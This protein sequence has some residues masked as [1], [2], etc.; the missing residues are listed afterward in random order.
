MDTVE[1]EPCSADATLEVHG[2]TDETQLEFLSLYFE[3]KRRSGGGT[4]KSIEYRRDY[5]LLTFENPAVAENVLANGRHKFN[6]IELIVRRARPQDPGKLLLCGLNPKTAYQTLEL[7]LELITGL[8]SNTMTVH[9]TPDRS[10]A[11]IHFKEALSKEVLRKLKEKFE[12]RRLDGASVRAEQ[13]RVTDRVLVENFD[14]DCLLNLYFESPRSHGGSVTKVTRLPG[15]R[16]VVTFHEWEAVD[17]VLKHEQWLKGQLLIIRPH[18]DFL[19]PPDSEPE[20]KARADAKP[21]VSAQPREELSSTVNVPDELKMELLRTS[22]LLRELQEAERS[23]VS[24]QVSEGSVRVTSRDSLLIER[25]K[26]RIL[27][28]LSSVAQATLTVTADEARFLSRSEVRD[29]LQASLL[30]QGAPARYSLSGGL[31]T[32][33][34]FS[35]ATAQAIAQLI[36][37]ELSHINV[38]VSDRQ[39]HALSSPDWQKLVSS[40]RCCQVQVSHSGDRVHLLTLGEFRAEAEKRLE[41]YFGETGLQESVIVMESGKLRFL[42]DNY[43]EVLAGIGQVSIVPL[44]GNDITGLRI[45]G[46][47]SACQP[48]DELLRSIISSICSSTVMLQ[49]PGIARFLL[50]ERGRNI[51]KQLETKYRCTFGLER[52]RWLPLEPEHSLDSSE[53]WI[54]PNFQRSGSGGRERSIQS[55]QQPPVSV[56]DPNGN[57]L[58]LG[59]ITNLIASIDGDEP[60][61]TSVETGNEAGEIPAARG[62]AATSEA[63]SPE[64][65]L[66]TEPLAQ[67]MSMA[68]EEEELEII[69]MDTVTQQEGGNEGDGDGERLEDSG[70]MLVASDKDL[71]FA[72]KLSLETFQT[73]RNLDEDAQ[74]LLALQC[75]MDNRSRE[76][77]E[78][79]KALELSMVESHRS[80]ELEMSNNMES[81]GA[82]AME[83]VLQMSIQDAVEASNSAQL[84]VYG[85]CDLDFRRVKAELEKIIQSNLRREEIEND[86]LQEL[87]SEHERYLSH[88][89][90]QHGVTITRRGAVLQV[91]GFADYTMR[92]STRVNRLVNRALREQ[93]AQVEEAEVARSV[94][95]VRYGAEEGAT[96]VPYPAS[97][98]AFIEQAFQ[99]KQKKVEVMFDHKPY[100]VNLDRMEEYNIGAAKALRIERQTL[101]SPTDQEVLTL[102]SGN[103]ELVRVNEATDEYRKLIRPFYDTLQDFYN[104]IRIVKVEKVNNPLLYQQYM[105]KKAKLQAVLGQTNVER[106]LYHGTN[107]ESA[108]E[109]YVHGFNRSF[110]GKNATLYGQGVYFATNAVM[111]A[112]DNYSPPN[113]QK[114]KFIFVV[115]VLTGAY[116]KG[117]S[118]MKAP[119]LKQDSTM[120]LR[121]DC[122][123]D[124]CRN[125]TIFVIFNDTQAYP[126]YL[127]TCLRN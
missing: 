48:A 60:M 110:C 22:R 43:H 34:G 103:I 101:G 123:V 2:I 23:E 118:S 86:C 14:D 119:P 102:A 106:V 122:V 10:Q 100:T 98:N 113:E 107:E 68:R 7:Y 81:S 115:N 73:E 32:V 53:K 114:H 69:E 80:M 97:A 27:E 121:Y 61:A 92:A 35:S 77:E 11:L 96:P 39:L 116:A 56:T 21:G 127:I 74:L 91:Y 94:K 117:E 25:T 125:P 70:M 49:H 12:S 26:N 13:V 28:F 17:R 44:E 75:S 54:T 83:D 79:Q 88:L 31:L 16:A 59:M 67:T 41:D 33:A 85:N 99:H 51:L 20:P 78:L 111:S 124:D 55:H 30:G 6:N 37:K 52:V 38:P 3:N 84:T 126:Q 58:D 71:E 87:S 89:Q 5:T 104:K 76:D 42:Q 93:K 95:W 63:S 47:A 109:I 66:Y 120:P 24:V 65:D 112:Q 40:L 15:G 8:D 46:S 36:K 64:E 9:Y 72:T 19:Q 108:K 4:I 50:E 45:S 1:Q 18:Y 29:H 57:R 105:L 90:R 82:S 62:S